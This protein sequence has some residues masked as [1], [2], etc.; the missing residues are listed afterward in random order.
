MHRK[1]SDDKIRRNLAGRVCS[2]TNQDGIESSEFRSQI[3]KGV[4]EL[5]RRLY[6]SEKLERFLRDGDFFIVERSNRFYSLSAIEEIMVYLEKN[7]IINP[8]LKSDE[9]QYQEDVYFGKFLSKLLPQKDYEDFFNKDSFYLY[10]NP[11][12][13]TR[14]RDG[15]YLGKMNAKEKKS[16]YDKIEQIF[17]SVASCL[18]AMPAAEFKKYSGQFNKYEDTAEESDFP[19]TLKILEEDMSSKFYVST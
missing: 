4:L 13:Y 1:I 8:E 2:D 9:I 17:I 15:N 7:A 6:Y 3:A 16:F 5:S 10:I 18:A 12:P 19:E 14:G 11:N